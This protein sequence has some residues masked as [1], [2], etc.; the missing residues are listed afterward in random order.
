MSG[1][2]AHLGDTDLGV[3]HDVVQQACGDDGL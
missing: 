2:L 3:L 1:Q